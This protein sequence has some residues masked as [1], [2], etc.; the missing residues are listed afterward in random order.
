MGFFVAAAIAQ[1]ST[2]GLHGEQRVNRKCRVLVIDPQRHPF[3]GDF[4]DTVI[5]VSFATG[6][7]VRHPIQHP[8]TALSLLVGEDFRFAHKC[9][10]AIIGLETHTC[11]IIFM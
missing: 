11:P 7:N 5:R 2:A 3:G 1:Q 6:E 8:K 4:Y 10:I 9:Y